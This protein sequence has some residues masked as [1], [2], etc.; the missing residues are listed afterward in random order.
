MGQGVEDGRSC[1]PEYVT[2]R[3]PAVL[4]PSNSGDVHAKF[5]AFQR[6]RYN[7]R[8]AAGKEPFDNSVYQEFAYSYTD[9]VRAGVPIKTANKAIWAAFKYYYKLGAFKPW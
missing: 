4:L 8:V 5:S 9:M 2:N 6:R 1:Q 7:R 3:A